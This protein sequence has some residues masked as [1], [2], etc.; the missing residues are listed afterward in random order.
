R[1]LMACLL[2]GSPNQPGCLADT[3]E[4]LALPL[5]GDRV[6]FHG[7]SEA[8]L[9]TE[10]EP[11]ERHVPRRLV[12]AAAQFVDALQP[13]L[14][15][16]DEAEHHLAIAGHRAERLEAAGAHVVVL[17]EEPLEARLAEHARDRAVAAAR[18]ELRLVVAATDVQAERDAGMTAAAGLRHL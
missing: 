3:R 2:C 12:D 10:R 15:R 13:L 6:A 11:V 1:I 9:R 17:E 16:G 8:A 18:V 5:R 14:L 7:R 4:L